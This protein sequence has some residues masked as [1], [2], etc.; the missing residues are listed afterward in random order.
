MAASPAPYRADGRGFVFAGEEV[1][2][3]LRPE[4]AAEIPD[5]TW[6][7]RI[8]RNGELLASVPGVVVTGEDDGLPD[9]AFTLSAETTRDLLPDDRSAIDLMHQVVRDPGGADDVVLSAPFQ[10]RLGVRP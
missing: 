6:E 10:V 4:P 7:Q 2:L 1:I 8:I 3:T 5:W 9:L